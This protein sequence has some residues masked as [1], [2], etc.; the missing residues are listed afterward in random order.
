M[1]YNAFDFW[2]KLCYGRCWTFTS[3]S[4]LRWESPRTLQ[5]HTIGICFLYFCKMLSQK[6]LLR[7]ITFFNC[8]LCPQST[9]FSVSVLSNKIQLSHFSYFCATKWN[10]LAQQHCHWIIKYWYWMSLYRYD[11]A[12]QTIRMLCCVDFFPHPLIC[13]LDLE[14]VRS[15]WSHW[16]HDS[17]YIHEAPGQVMTFKWTMTYAN[18][19]WQS[20]MVE[21]TQTGLGRRTS[22]GCTRDMLWYGQIKAFTG[23]PPSVWYCTSALLRRSCHCQWKQYSE[24]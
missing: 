14:T 19:L 12:T 5:H 21:W 1:I 7:F 16:G 9:A 10:S 15:S 3:G 23:Q 22:C 8:K 18:W 20:S 24:Y 17:L 11:I 13:I 4:L 2:S 6:H